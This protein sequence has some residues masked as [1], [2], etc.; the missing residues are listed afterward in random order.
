M[1]A[2]FRVKIDESVWHLKSDKYSKKQVLNLNRSK[3]ND[4]L[5]K[6]TKT[7][8]RLEKSNSVDS[9]EDYN[10]TNDTSDDN[11]SDVSNESDD[12]L[13]QIEELDELNLTDSDQSKI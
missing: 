10:A 6:T 11:D 13:Y 12:D 7:R 2:S 8:F 1:S 3:S 4:S 9:I 5:Y